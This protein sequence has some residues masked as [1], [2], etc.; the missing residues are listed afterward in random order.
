MKKEKEKASVQW[1]DKRMRLAEVYIPMQE[2]RETFDPQEALR[3][4]T[5]FPELYRP[6]RKRPRP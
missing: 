4:G 2:Y 1:Y 3:R 5:I 6:Y